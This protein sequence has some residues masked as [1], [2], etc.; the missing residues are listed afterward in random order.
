MSSMQHGTGSATS[1]GAC[2]QFGNP[3]SSNPVQR[4]L[5]LALDK[6]TFGT[7]PPPSMVPRLD[8]GTMTLPASTGFPTNIPDPFGETPNGKVTYTGLKT[9]RHR[10]ILGANFYTTGIPT[11]F[12]PVITPP[13]EIETLVPLPANVNGPVYPSYAPT[14]DS[15]GN[16][17]AG[18]RLP[19]VTV[20]IATYTGWALRSGPQANDGCESTGQ[21]IPFPATAATRASSGDPRPSVAERYPTFDDYDSKVKTAMN[22]MIQQRTL[23]CED[24]A[25]ELQRM[26]TLG[27]SRGVPNPP[28]SFTPFSFALAN[29]TAVSSRTSLSPA[30]GAMVPVTLSMSAPDTCNV[31]C[32][33]TSIAG[34][35]GATSADWQI[36]GP[37]SASLRATAVGRTGR[38]YKLALTCTDPATNLSAIKAA[39]VTVPAPAT[40]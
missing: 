35:D 33:L 1:R 20:P 4:A 14:T 22:A 30:N 5:W 7:A 24:G 26:R 19:D 16:D 12:P 21:F 15:D 9:T 34:T 2:Q 11:I 37:M 18:V 40:E 27:A 32:N 36:T 3:L 31:S 13:L 8:N 38:L 25:S 10:F 6:W 17:I 28:A 39:A 23:L 29:S